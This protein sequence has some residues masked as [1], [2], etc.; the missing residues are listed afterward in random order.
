VD[1]DRFDD[2]LRSIGDPQSRRRVMRAVGGLVLA[3]LVRAVVS[4]ESEARNT[5]KQTRT[6]WK[7]TKGRKNGEHNNSDRNTQRNT[8]EDCRRLDADGGCSEFADDNTAC[9]HD[10]QCYRGACVARPTCVPAFG[11]CT[12]VAACCAESCAP[13]VNQ[14]YYS[15]VNQP[16][17]KNRDCHPDQH[18]SCIGHR[19]RLA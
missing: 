12:G 14:C 5:P 8:C 13:M 3:G 6:R 1:G 2:L 17:Y 7:K 18:L 15:T 9:G 4:G 19:C 11:S 16:C 10:G